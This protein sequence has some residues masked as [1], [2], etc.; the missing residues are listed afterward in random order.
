MMNFQKLNSF[1]FELNFLIYFRFLKLNLGPTC[2][3]AVYYLIEN[4]ALVY[5]N[6]DESMKFQD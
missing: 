3:I 4:D 6:V 1:H 2:F 5:L